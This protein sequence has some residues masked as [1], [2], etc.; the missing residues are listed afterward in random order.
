MWLIREM[1]CQPLSNFL[2]DYTKRIQ[3]V[4]LGHGQQ[5]RTGNI[6][7]LT[8]K[9]GPD[10]VIKSLIWWRRSGSNRLPLECH[11]SA[12]PS[13]LRPQSSIIIPQVFPFVNHYFIG[14]WGWQ[15]EYYYQKSTKTYWL[16]VGSKFYNIGKRRGRGSCTGSCGGGGSSCKVAHRE[17]HPYII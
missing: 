3:T 14:F 2:I 1:P 5:R 8:G 13:E 6:I 11:S 4:L 17:K 16:R 10:P 7:A 15:M 12:L 9:K